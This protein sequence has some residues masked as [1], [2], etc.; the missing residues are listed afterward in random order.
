MKFLV[1]LSVDLI[2]LKTA[3][4]MI[5]YVAEEN[6]ALYVFSCGSFLTMPPLGTATT[7]AISLQK[8]SFNFKDTTCTIS[9][10][11]EISGD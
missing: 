1:I 8:L 7:V 10:H 2:D 6:R 3:M 9:E 4:W 11:K 5:R